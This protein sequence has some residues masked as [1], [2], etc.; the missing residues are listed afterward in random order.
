VIEKDNGL[1]DFQQLQNY[2]N[3]PVGELKYFVFDMLFLNGH[4]IEEFPLEKR[5]ELLESFFGKYRF[6][7]IYLAPFQTGGGKKLFEELSAKGYEG[8]IAKDPNGSYQQGKRTGLWLKIKAI[9]EQEAIICGYTMPQKGR[10]YFGSILLGMYDNGRLKYVGNCGTGFSD[11]SL[12][13]LHARFEKLRVDASPF[14]PVPVMSYTKGKPVWIKPELV[15]NIKFTEFTDKDHFRHPVFLGVREDKTV[16]EITKTAMEQVLEKS[17]ESKVFT[18]GE[19][20]VKCTNLNKVY[21]PEEG[22]TKGDLIKYY[23]GISKYI[24]PHL[25]DRPQSLNRYP[26]GINAPSFYHKNMEVKHLPDWVKTHKVTS[27]SKEIDYLICNDVATLIYMANL[28]CIEIHPWHS[29]RQRPSCPTYMM[30]DLDPGDIDFKE[31]VNVALVVKEICDELEIPSYCKT[32]GSRGLHI[33]IPLGAAYSYGQ[34]KLFSELLAKIAHS[35]IPTITS[36]ERSKSKRKNKIYI[37]FLQNR[38]SQTIAAP[39][40]VRP[41]PMATVSAPLKWNEVNHQLSPQMFTMK[42]MITR[43]EKMGDIWLPVLNQQI[44][45]L[46]VLDKIENLD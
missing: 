41:R 28:G 37:D 14:D 34:I 27:D 10:K 9:R 11:T 15:C 16:E 2:S 18:F 46:Q 6:R 13:E 31:V 42:N 12:K 26:N 33:F 36:I 38:K 32:S 8:I 29:T 20:K 21:W 35:R 25:K 43:V 7:N 24:L 44:D 4:S 45:L 19:K 1:N 40:S 23:Q 17:P 30:I 3:H 5:K 22:Y 39:Y